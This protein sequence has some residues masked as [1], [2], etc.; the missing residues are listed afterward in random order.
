MEG[1][2]KKKAHRV[3]KS[4]R[5]A[6]KKSKKDGKNWKEEGLDPK[7]RN[8]KVSITHIMSKLIKVQTSTTTLQTPCYQEPGPQN[9][10]LS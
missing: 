9:V 2:D 8:P 1:D 5:K 6:D 7:I 3:S 4:G 10:V